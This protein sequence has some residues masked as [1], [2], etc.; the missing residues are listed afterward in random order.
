VSGISFHFITTV[1]TGA[2]MAAGV[3][4][5]DDEEQPDALRLRHPAAV[6][7]TFVGSRWALLR[8][9]STPQRLCPRWGRPE[10][11]RLQLWNNRASFIPSLDAAA[12]FASRNSAHPPKSPH[13]FG[14][15]N[16][17]LTHRD[18]EPCV[19]RIRFHLTNAIKFSHVQST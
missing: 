16:S 6:C 1:T 9:S 17:H 4:A 7:V 8:A 3:V 12:Y 18:N 13:Y 2:A 10:I 19:R 11:I 5:T 14:E 15:H